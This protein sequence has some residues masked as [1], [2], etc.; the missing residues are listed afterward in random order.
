MLLIILAAREVRR[1]GGDPVLDQFHGMQADA[2]KSKGKELEGATLLLGK[3][4]ACSALLKP[5]VSGTSK[6][7]GEAL[8]NIYRNL[9]ELAV[10]M[11]HARLKVLPRTRRAHTAAASP[12]R[13]RLSYVA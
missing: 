8:A 5:M 6:K 13:R 4:G 2:A 11:M 10:K 1:N 3:Y 7:K 9:H 12:T